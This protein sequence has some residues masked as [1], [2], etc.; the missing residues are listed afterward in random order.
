MHPIASPWL[1][2]PI[3]ITHGGS[4]LPV[5]TFRMVR[6]LAEAVALIRPESDAGA[7]LWGDLRVALDRYRVVCV[8]EIGMGDVYEAVKN[9]MRHQL[10]SVSQSPL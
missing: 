3:I 9:L 8:S 1:H 5:G 4:T 2:A 6:S 10:I 7:E